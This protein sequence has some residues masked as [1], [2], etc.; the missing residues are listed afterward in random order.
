MR[1]V[2]VKS[3]ESPCNGVCKVNSQG[4]CVGCWRT[5][6]EIEEA[7]KVSRID[8]IGQNGNDGLHYTNKRSDD[9]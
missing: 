9:E 4:V 3:S 6:K 2:V 1:L 5:L 7:G 8:I